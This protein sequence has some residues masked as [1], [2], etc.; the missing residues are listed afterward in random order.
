MYETREQTNDLNLMLILPNKFVGQCGKYECGFIT[1]RRVMVL[2]H[3]IKYQPEP[4]R[5]VI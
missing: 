4:S 1:V 2:S 5:G 3:L